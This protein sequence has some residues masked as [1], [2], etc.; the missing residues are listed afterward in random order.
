MMVLHGTSVAALS[1]GLVRHTGSVVVESIVFQS[2]GPSLQLSVLAMAV[3]VDWLS[4]KA[5][6]GMSSN[7]MS[8]SGFIRLLHCEPPRTPPEFGEIP[9]KNPGFAQA[10]Q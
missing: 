6:S 8:E 7:W 10:V 2:F 4:M 1:S 5:K 9:A 3:T